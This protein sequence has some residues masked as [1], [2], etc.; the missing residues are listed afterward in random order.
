MKGGHCMS[1][2][3]VWIG[4]GL[5][6]IALL[7]SFGLARNPEPQSSGPQESAETAAIDTASLAEGACVDCHQDETPTLV[8]DFQQGT[9]A[10][11]GMDCSACHGSEH[12]SAQDADEAGLPTAQTCARCHNDK[13]QQ[14]KGGKH[15]LAWTAQNAMPATHYQPMEL[16]EGKK[17]CG[18]CHKIGLK[19]EEE[20]RGLQ[21]Q[22]HDYGVASC[23]SCHTRH[24]FSVEEARQPEACATCHMGFDHAQWEMWTT[25]KHGVRYQ[26]KRQGVL[27]EEAAAP[28]CQTC[29]MQDGDH[30]V[31]TAWGF[32]A[33]RLPM[34]EDEEW[35]AD[36]E[37][38]LKALGVLNPNT[39]EPTAR[40]DA[41]KA[42]DMARLDAE[43]WQAE[44]A[45]MLDTCSQC[46]SRNFAQNEL[47]KGDQLIRQADDLMA[48][49]IEI[50]AGLYED[51]ALEKPESYSFAYPDLLT[52][53]EAMTPIEQTLFQMFLKHR[54]RTFQ[55]AFHNNPD[56]T[57]WYGWSEMRADLTEIEAEAQELRAEQ[58]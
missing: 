19:S 9:M 18:S 25:S 45:E 23:D 29:H 17:G 12:T 11:S 16:I 24:A 48:A 49:A 34:P 56:Y 42:A 3:L 22:G 39:G 20:I 46:H 43:S 8:R 5:I 41:V 13:F 33:V 51:G 50:V 54:M 36:R 27:S 38:I 14:F 47:Q 53:N 6:G 2:R 30:E 37:T 15:A 26:L 32:L 40:L 10:Q 4:V 57:F 7:V 55:G 35:A 1:I 28:T 52:F 44:R 21:D 58:E 31:R